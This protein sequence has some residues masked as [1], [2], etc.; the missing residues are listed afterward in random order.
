MA[1]SIGLENHHL[2]T[3][4]RPNFDGGT[5]SRSFIVADWLKLNSWRRSPRRTKPLTATIQPWEIMAQHLCLLVRKTRRAGAKGIS[6]HT[7]A[8]VARCTSCWTY[9]CAELFMRVT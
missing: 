5:P 7:L 4:A 9:C 6:G 3:T 8:G 1:G 2:I